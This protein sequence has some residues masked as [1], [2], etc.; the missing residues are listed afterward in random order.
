MY[1]VFWCVLVHVYVA[2]CMYRYA[3][4][5]HVRMC[6]CSSVHVTN[7][8]VII[9]VVLGDIDNINSY[10]GNNIIVKFFELKYVCLLCLLLRFE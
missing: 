3:Q 1:L 8:N 10:R 5:L 7:I 6:K 2:V 4:L 9:I